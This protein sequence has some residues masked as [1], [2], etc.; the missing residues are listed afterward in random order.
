M[1]VHLTLAFVAFLWGVN[2]PV[3]K[4]GLLYIDPLPYNAIRLIVALTAGWP[5]FRY[6]A[7]WQPLLREDWKALAI[8]GLG[9]FFFQAFF[10]AGVQN[11]TAGNASLILGCLPISVA[12]INHF[13][14]FEQIARNMLISISISLLGVAVMVAGTGN[15]VSFAGEHVFG[16]VMLLAAQL[17][18]GYY[19]IFSRRLINHYS[20]YQITAYILVIATGLF[21][22]VALPSV[23]AVNWWNVPLA[24]WNSILY[25]GL[26][27]L[28]LGN[29]LWIW[30]TGILGSTK[31]SL[32]NNLPPVFAIIAGYSFLHESF[33]WLQTL[34]A[35]II[36][37]GLYKAKE[38]PSPKSSA[39]QPP[40]N[41]GMS[42]HN[43]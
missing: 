39:H 15:T 10:T 21:M 41:N 23:L 31:A 4:I 27:P 38:P 2:P 24:G 7:C 25:S 30:G 3:M 1:R 33:G 34:G 29:C 5:L 19:T 32:Y 12:L 28:C 8:A 11:T 40:P 37:T 17:S 36:F 22:L 13:H 14:K 16:A 9:F 35:L 42:Q 18:Y 26:F 20:T 43:Q 6:L